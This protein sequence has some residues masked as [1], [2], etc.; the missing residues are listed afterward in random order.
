M[1]TFPRSGNQGY[2][3]SNVEKRSPKRNRRILCCVLGFGVHPFR[4]R[5]SIT[6][7]GGSRFVSPGIPLLGGG[8]MVLKNQSRRSFV[9]TSAMLTA[10]G[11]LSTHRRETVA[12]SSQAKIRVGII[13][14]TGKGDYGHSVDVAFTK[15]PNVEIVALADENDAGRKAAADRTNPK[16]TYA[17]YREMFAKEKMDLV[18]IC[19]RWIDQHHEMI[20]AAADAG[21]HVY[22]EKPFCPTL[23]DCDSAIQALEKKNLKLGIAHISQYSPV[24]HMAKSLITGGEIGDLLELRAR[25]KEDRRGGGEDLWVLGSHVFGMMRAFAGGNP[26]SCSATV[27][28]DGKPISKKQVAMGAEGIGLLAGDN[29]QAR[30][31]FANGVFG[32]FA[33]RKNKA[34]EPT[35]FAIQVFGS[36]GILELES[37]YLAQGQLLRDSSWSPGRSK[38]SW[39]PFSSAGIGIAEP[40]KDGTYQGGHVAAILDL[41]ECIRQD[42][43]PICSANDSRS[44]V[45]MIASVFESQRLGTPVE[46]PMKTRVNPLS[47]L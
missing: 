29:V 20:L 45:E 15:I 39:E 34:G 44:I 42:R 10:G 36:K 16:K 2:S 30:Y 9:Q 41:L 4:D 14:R 24:L 17:D 21:C 6:I 11:I 7:P 31:A 46:L 3:P 37:G 35:R 25:G 22:M 8:T 47:L 40:R 33:S 27:L 38:K 18:A 26:A 28:Q 5:Q 23:A 12:A 1:L 32:H 13:G 19:P 43:T